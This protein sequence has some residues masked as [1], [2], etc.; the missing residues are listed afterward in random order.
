M[1]PT[2][3]FLVGDE[4]GYSVVKNV[5][6]KK[7]GSLR[8][9]GVKYI[10]DTSYWAYLTIVEKVN[11][12]I[13]RLENNDRLPLF[14]SCCPVWVKYLEVFYPQYQSNLSTCKSHIL[15]KNYC[16]KK[17]KIDKPVVVIVLWTAKNMK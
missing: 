11:E 15:I 7:V 1:S 6:S 17:N 13:K 10:F 16:A 8:K 4:Y 12:L 9:L 2:V 14:T 3:R 5:L